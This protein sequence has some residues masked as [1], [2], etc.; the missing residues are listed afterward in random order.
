METIQE[1][2]PWSV[3]KIVP[4]LLFPKYLQFCMPK[5]ERMDE[6]CELGE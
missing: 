4:I 2:G 5:G 6:E 3:Y 1:A